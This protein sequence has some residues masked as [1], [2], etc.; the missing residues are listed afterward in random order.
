MVLLHYWLLGAMVLPMPSLNVR[1]TVEQH[2]ALRELAFR[3]RRSM[4]SLVIGR[5]FANG[6]LGAGAPTGRES[7]ADAG[8]PRGRSASPAPAPSPPPAGEHEY[9]PEQRLLGFKR[10]GRPDPKK[11]K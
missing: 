3:E 2:E 10:P 1:L 7:V 11:G 4:Q 5:L 6:G 8:T 9:A